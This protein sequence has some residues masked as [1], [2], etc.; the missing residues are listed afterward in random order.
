LSCSKNEDLNQQV[1]VV[2]D[3]I[4]KN[5]RK[6]IS[7]IA[8][9]LDSKAKNLVANWLDYQEL[10]VLM[11]DYYA[12]S[13]GDAYNNT[14][15]LVLLTKNIKDSIPF[16]KLQVDAMRVR[17]NVLHNE[18]LRINDMSKLTNVSRADLT[19]QIRRIIAAFSA[20][21]AKLNELVAVES[22]ET[23]MQDYE[24]KMI[25]Q[26]LVEKSKAIKR[27]QLTLPKEKKKNFKKK[28]TINN[29]K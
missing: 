20:T 3:S 15:E 10:D 8:K 13:V 4:P 1:D 12:I 14:E 23:Y 2:Q 18:A 24:S 17:F 28:K 29:K 21:N 11:T 5:T 25:E 9:I 19:A 7:S 16:K 27:K 6:I 26:L 22:L